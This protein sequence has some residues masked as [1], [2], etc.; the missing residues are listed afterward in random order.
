MQLVYIYSLDRQ[1]SSKATNLVYSMISV[2]LLG[3]PFLA[4][5]GNIPFIE[6]GTFLGI[7]QIPENA[8]TLALVNSV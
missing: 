4:S 1:R 3:M 6:S 5:F 7:Y 2:Q 8:V